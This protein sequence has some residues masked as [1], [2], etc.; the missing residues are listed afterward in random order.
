M[1][2]ECQTTDEFNTLIK[3]PNFSATIV[4][5]YA[6]WCPPCKIIKPFFEQLSLKHTDVQFVKVDVDVLGDVAQEVGIR[7][8]P[9]FVLFRNGVKTGERVEGASKAGIVELIRKC[10]RIAPAITGNDEEGGED[11]NGNGTPSTADNS[12]DTKPRKRCSC[13][14][15]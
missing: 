14:I 6:V 8:M 10:S 13:S 2:V 11:K 12:N 9:T 5:F 7:A 1:V 4:D 3:D 15:L